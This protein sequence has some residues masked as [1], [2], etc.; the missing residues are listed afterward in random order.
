LKILWPFSFQDC[1]TRDASTGLFKISPGFDKRIYDI[2]AW[3]FEP[4]MFEKFPEL[5]GVAPA[6]NS[7]PGKVDEVR[8]R[9]WS[10]MASDDGS[11]GRSKGKEIERIGKGAEL[12]VD[13][14]GLKWH[15]ITDKGKDVVYF[16]F[17]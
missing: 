7:I 4:K 16:T 2:N 17:G 3:T 13:S 8:K 6:F 9:R 15:K 11:E 14:R 1:Y 5:Y 10:V 12:G